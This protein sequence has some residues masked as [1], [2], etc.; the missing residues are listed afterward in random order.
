MKSIVEAVNARGSVLVQGDAHSTLA[1][2]IMT[3]AYFAA[4]MLKIFVRRTREKSSKRLV[5]I[6]ILSQNEG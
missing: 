6:S 1:G 3:V 2:L 5:I 4:E